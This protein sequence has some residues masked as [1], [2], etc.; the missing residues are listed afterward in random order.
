MSKPSDPNAE[1]MKRLQEMQKEQLMIS[2]LTKELSTILDKKQLQLVIN[3][4]FKTELGSNDCMMIRD[5]KGNIEI[6]GNG[7]EN[8]IH[9]TDQQLDRYVKNCLDSAEPLLFDLKELSPL[10]SC[11]TEAKNSG[12]RMA[13]GLGL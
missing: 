4:S 3:T 6:F 10:P 5:V 13:V 7:T 12:M 9:T 1:M 8:Q 2:R 11:F